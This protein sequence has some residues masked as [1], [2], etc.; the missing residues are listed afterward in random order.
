MK[1]R[2]QELIDL[3]NAYMGVLSDLDENNH[4]D[5][6]ALMSLFDPEIDYQIPFLEKPLRCRGRDETRAFLDRVQGTFTEVEYDV[7]H[8]YVDEEQDTIIIEMTAKRR[9]LPGRELYSNR[10]VMR[11]TFRERRIAELR[12]YLNPL[13][14]A[15]L[16]ARLD[17]N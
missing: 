4:R 3:S 10:Y 12:E 6:D 17:L 16:S 13:A 5:M 15:P 1:S 11:L 9:L 8:R 2:K 7:E 14:A